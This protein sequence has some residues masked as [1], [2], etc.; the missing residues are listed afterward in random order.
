MNEKFRHRNMNNFAMRSKRK[1]MNMKGIVQELMLHAGQVAGLFAQRHGVPIPY[2]GQDIC[3]VDAF[4]EILRRRL[5]NPELIRKQIAR[6]CETNPPEYYLGK[7]PYYSEGFTCHVQVTAPMRSAFDMISHFQIMGK[8]LNGSPPYSRSQ[9]QTALRLQSGISKKVRY[10]QKSIDRYKANKKKLLGRMS[11]ASDKSERLSCASEIDDFVPDEPVLQE[12]G[13]LYYPKKR[14]HE[15]WKSL[16]TMK[17]P[18]RPPH[19]RVTPGNGVGNR[20]PLRY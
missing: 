8:L 3:S 2:R 9:L 12:K 4:K 5:K 7:T 10:C 19:L 14:T 11:D 1:P 6:I 13:Q 16:N 15:N 18:Y 17:R 20:Y